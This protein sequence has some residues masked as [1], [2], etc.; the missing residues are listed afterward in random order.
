M[1][2]HAAKYT[3]IVKPDSIAIGTYT[4]D[5]RSTCAIDIHTGIVIHHFINDARSTVDT[6]LIIISR[7]YTCRIIY[8]RYKT[9]RNYNWYWYSRSNT[10]NDLGQVRIMELQLSMYNS[11][12]YN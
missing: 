3:N 8:L 9:Y 7:L 11:K 10:T 12:I 6:H 5:K 1:V 2:A 4:N